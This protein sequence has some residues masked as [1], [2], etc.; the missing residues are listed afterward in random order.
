MFTNQSSVTSFSEVCDMNSDRTVFTQLLSFVSFE[1]FHFFK[2]SSTVAI[3]RNKAVWRRRASLIMTA[4]T[5]TIPRRSPIA[6]A[7]IANGGY[8]IDS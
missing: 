5:I 2:D 1:R 8:T 7:T 6:T 3:W 4:N